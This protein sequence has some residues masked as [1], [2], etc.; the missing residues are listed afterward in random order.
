MSQQQPQRLALDRVV[1]WHLE[2]IR[3]IEGALLLGFYGAII[4]ILLSKVFIGKCCIPVISSSQ[5]VWVP[6][7][8]FSLI[9]LGIV[10]KLNAELHKH[11]QAVIE[12]IR[13]EGRQG[14]G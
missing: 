1:E 5:Y 7:F 13:R 4:S 8:L 12:Y 6:I 9:F 14:G 10:Y 2:H 11:W 3:H